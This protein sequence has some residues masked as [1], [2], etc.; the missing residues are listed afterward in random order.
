MGDEKQAP[1][2]PE[3][4][5]SAQE[6][7]IEP[8]TTPF[9]NAVLKGQPGTDVGDLELELCQ[10]GGKVCSVSAWDLNERQRELVAA[11]AHIRLGVYQ[12]PIPPLSMSIEAPFCPTCKAA[13]VYVK[14]EGSFFCAGAC[15]D[16]DPRF[17][18]ALSSVN[19]S[20]ADTPLEQAHQDFAPSD[21][22]DDSPAAA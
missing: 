17:G 10:E 20:P 14:A 12:H 13:M 2:I 15:P 8:S 11:G 5:A 21:D 19:G 22:D 16:R 4:R 7:W 9:T 6:D 18:P 1:V 3:M